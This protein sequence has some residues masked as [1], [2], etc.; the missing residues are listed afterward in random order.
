MAFILR[1]YLRRA[2]NR[3]RYLV[4]RRSKS[5]YT[6]ALWRSSAVK[7]RER[8]Q[9]TKG[10]TAESKP[11][12]QQ[13]ERVTGKSSVVIT[14][15]VKVPSVMVRMQPEEQDPHLVGKLPP[16]TLVRMVTCSPANDVTTPGR[17][18]ARVTTSPPSEL[19]TV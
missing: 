9:S 2:N 3:K 17:L 13:G 18:P 6:R 19:S 12:V 7:L 16:T 8:D 11:E 15:S 5:R 10:N 14:S 4:H 1:H